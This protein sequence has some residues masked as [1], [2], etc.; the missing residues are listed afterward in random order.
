MPLR[1]RTPHA[2]HSVFGP[3]GP[4]R[5][6]GV[7]WHPQFRHPRRTLCPSAVMMLSVAFGAQPTADAWR[8]RF[9]PR[10]GHPVRSPEVLDDLVAQNK[11][12]P[13]RAVKEHAQSKPKLHN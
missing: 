8:G 3:V 4:M 10:D 7:F 9:P 6:C 1:N 13:T 5:H 12:F 11:P 2:L